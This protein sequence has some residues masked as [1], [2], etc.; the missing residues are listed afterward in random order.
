MSENLDVVGGFLWGG[1]ANFGCFRLLAK[2]WG[3]IF[4]KYLSNELIFGKSSFL[5]T[6]ESKKYVTF[7]FWKIRFLGERLIFHVHF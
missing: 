6:S 5:F 2:L 1:L 4:R 3:P 7:F